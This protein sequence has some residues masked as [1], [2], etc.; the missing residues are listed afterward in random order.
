M[1]H[2]YQNFL[3]LNNLEQYTDTFERIFEL[4][5]RVRLPKSSFSCTY[6]SENDGQEV[7]ISD[8]YDALLSNAK[9]VIL[10]YSINNEHEIRIDFLGLIE[11]LPKRK[12]FYIL[13]AGEK[14]FAIFQE[15]KMKQFLIH[16]SNMIFIAQRLFY[17]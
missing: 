6:T 17:L 5:K 2:K 12:Y 1:N 16:P 3:E 13:L 15:E 10:K 7:Q 9:K 11:G 14:H 4:L 8:E